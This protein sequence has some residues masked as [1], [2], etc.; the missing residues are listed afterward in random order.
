MGAIRIYLF[1]NWM[2]LVTPLATF[3]IVAAGGLFAR[4]ILF[5]IRTV[6]RKRDSSR[7]VSAT[8]G[9]TN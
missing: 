2:M 1:E 5:P 7:D 4:R 3:S 6:V 9:G 8:R